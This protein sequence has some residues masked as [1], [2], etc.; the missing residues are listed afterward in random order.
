MLK[1]LVG[2]LV[3]VSLF[4]MPT[5][6]Y[7]H[8]EINYTKSFVKFS[9]DTHMHLKQP[10]IKRPTLGEEDCDWLNQCIIITLIGIIGVAMITVVVVVYKKSA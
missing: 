1:I 9:D 7:G 10:E 3:V 4:F 6:I 5:S 2:V 8:P